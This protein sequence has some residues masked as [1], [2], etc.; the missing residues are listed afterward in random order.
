MVVVEGGRHQGVV[1]VVTGR[2]VVVVVEGRFHHG[3]VV[4]DGRLVVVGLG[5]LVVVGFG[6]RDVIHGFTVVVVLKNS[7]PGVGGR[8]GFSENY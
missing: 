4:V 3:V 5:R 7:S 1:V 6:R 8:F 2:L